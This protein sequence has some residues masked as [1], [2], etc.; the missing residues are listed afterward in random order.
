MLKFSS[1]VHKFKKRKLITSC[2]SWRRAQLAHFYK[3]IEKKVRIA[4]H[5]ILCHKK[6]D[7]Y[8]MQVML[9]DRYVKFL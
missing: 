1:N 9:R 7:S 4:K 3:D 6:F 5:F 8:R 2:V